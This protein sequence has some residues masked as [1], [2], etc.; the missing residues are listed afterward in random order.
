MVAPRMLQR[1]ARMVKGNG[2]GGDGSE[3]YK[4]ATAMKPILLLVTKS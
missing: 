3:S 2:S 4:V 1:R